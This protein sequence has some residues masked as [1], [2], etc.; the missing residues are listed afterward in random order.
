M[1]F[2]L[3]W[4]TGLHYLM[5]VILAGAGLAV[6]LIGFQSALI[7]L[8]VSFSVLLLFAIILLRVKIE[9]R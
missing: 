9:P 2:S 6:M 5:S 7:L 8:I 1:G 4:A 3:K